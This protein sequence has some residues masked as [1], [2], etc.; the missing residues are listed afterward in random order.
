MTVPTHPHVHAA[1]QHLI[2]ALEEIE[3]AGNQ[4]AARHACKALGALR[5][6]AHRSTRKRIVTPPVNAP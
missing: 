3:K 1:I 2:W 6:V 5:Q 4:G